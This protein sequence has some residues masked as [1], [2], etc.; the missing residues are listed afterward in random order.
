MKRET[1][2]FKVGDPV[3][4]KSKRLGG[5]VTEVDRPDGRIGVTIAIM[6]ANNAG[7]RTAIRKELVK[8][9]DLEV[10]KKKRGVVFV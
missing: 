6:S 2:T 8:P 4:I 3:I 5:Q 1:I 10:I 7:I 9:E